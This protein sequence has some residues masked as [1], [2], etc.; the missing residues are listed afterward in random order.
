[1]YL[2][3]GTNG[4]SYRSDCTCQIDCFSISCP[5]RVVTKYM[6]KHVSTWITRSEGYRC[7]L[8]YQPVGKSS[9]KRKQTTWERKLTTENYV[10]YISNRWPW[11]NMLCILR[12]SHIFNPIFQHWLNNL[13][14]V[15]QQITWSLQV[16]LSNI[17]PS[18]DNLWP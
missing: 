12:G 1:M 5:W 3:P 14:S 16:Y 11:A 17:I 8:F 4:K 7:I 10:A 6:Y 2:N 9:L 15:I 13:L 18:D